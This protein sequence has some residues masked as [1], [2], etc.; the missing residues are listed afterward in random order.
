M[1][2][3]NSEAAGNEAHNTHTYLEAREREEGVRLSEPYQIALQINV[4]LSGLRQRL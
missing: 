4:G 3:V 1:S 2:W